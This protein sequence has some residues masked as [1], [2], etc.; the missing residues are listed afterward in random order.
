MANRKYKLLLGFDPSI[1]KPFILNKYYK[2]KKIELWPPP[3][4]DPGNPNFSTEYIRIC[5][6]RCYYALIKNDNT[7]DKYF[8]KSIPYE[9]K[10]KLKK[11]KK[12]KR[13]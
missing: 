1:V 11:L 8:E 9:R 13:I 3:W 2:I 10:Q 7:I 5:L 4:K 12:L 6:G